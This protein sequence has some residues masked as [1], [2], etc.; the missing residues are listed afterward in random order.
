MQV[1][2]SEPQR[3]TSY[4][5]GPPTHGD[6]V[7]DIAQTHLIYLIQYT[8]GPAGPLLEVN[9]DDENSEY[10]TVTSGITADKCNNVQLISILPNFTNYYFVRE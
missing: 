2:E 8:D 9:C 3:H 7:T 1:C 6:A 5:G 4:G 10:S